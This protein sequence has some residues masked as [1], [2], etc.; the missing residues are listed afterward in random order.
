[1][2]EREGAEPTPPSHDV[3]A[4][5]AALG[6]AIAPPV[7]PHRIEAEE[8]KLMMPQIESAFRLAD[9]DFDAAT[10]IEIAGDTAT[11]RSHELLGSLWVREHE[12]ITRLLGQEAT[13]AGEMST[14]AFGGLSSDE[15]R[16]YLA[17]D[18]G[19]STSYDKVKSELEHLIAE[20]L[21]D[22]PVSFVS[23]NKVTYLGRRISATGAD[24]IEA[25]I[26][27]FAAGDVTQVR[28]TIVFGPDEADDSDVLTPEATPEPLNVVQKN[29][30]IQALAEANRRLAVLASLDNQTLAA[31]VATH[32]IDA[33]VFEDNLGGSNDWIH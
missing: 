1:M 20:G 15:R 17:G 24:V 22:Q 31:A 28:E 7:M 12:L 25:I 13:E 19:A 14:L 3:R 8:S 5:E 4:A 32:R 21:T 2:T 26:Y 11:N 9:G 27:Q 33:A 16:K 6:F 23:P 18:T 30:L 29:A 10:Q